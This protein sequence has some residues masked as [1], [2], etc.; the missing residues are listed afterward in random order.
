V[1]SSDRAPVRR[2]PATRPVASPDTAP[3]GAAR[4]TRPPCRGAGRSA[5]AVRAATCI[6]LLAAAL[7]A[8]PASADPAELPRARAVRATASLEAFPATDLCALTDALIQQVRVDEGDW[9]QPGDTLVLLDR[10][11]LALARERANFL[12]RRRQAYLD[13]AEAL[14]AQGGI[15]AQDLE[16]LRYQAEDARLRCAQAELDLSRTVLRAPCAGQVAECRAEPGHVASTGQVLLVLIDPTDLRADVYLPPGLLSTVRIGGT[17][18]AVPIDPPVDPSAPTDSDSTPSGSRPAAGSEPSTST[19]HTQHALTGR[20]THI[21]PVLDLHSGQARVRIL[22][23]GAGRVLR[24]GTLVQI[25]LT[26][27]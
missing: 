6:H 22:F 13:R 23:P 26:G 3:L 20:V 16:T 11:E 19:I 5:R 9:V 12:A 21:S 1:T 14:H 4:S 10:S 2:H 15:S 27:D 18:L 7:S 17:A 25:Q 24:P 8:A